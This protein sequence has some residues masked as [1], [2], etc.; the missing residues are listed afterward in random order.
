VKSFPFPNNRE[1]RRLLVAGTV[2]V[3]AY[4][5]NE[6]GSTDIVAG[7]IGTHALIRDIESTLNSMQSRLDRLK[8]DV[9]DAIPFPSDSDRGPFR[10]RAA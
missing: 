6:S 4:P 2:N 3:P 1:A 10:P 5:D 8:R 9:N 7:R